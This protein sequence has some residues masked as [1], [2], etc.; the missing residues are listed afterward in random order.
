MLNSL[1]SR[2]NDEL[3][4]PARLAVDLGAPERVIQNPRE[5][6]VARDAHIGVFAVEVARECCLFIAFVLKHIFSA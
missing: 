2:L 1:L 6:I 3:H 4:F 5:I